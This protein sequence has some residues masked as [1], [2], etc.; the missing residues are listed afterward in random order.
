MH[1]MYDPPVQ[2]APGA[3]GPWSALVARVAGLTPDPGAPGGGRGRHGLAPLA[4]AHLGSNLSSNVLQLQKSQQAPVCPGQAATHRMRPA[5]LTCCF[6]R[7]FTETC[8]HC[9]AF[10]LGSGAANITLGLT[11]APLV[12]AGANILQISPSL[13]STQDHTRGAGASK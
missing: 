2:Y 12:R 5:F 11:P 3:G 4:P 13:S 7:L 9:T 8:Q 6:S 10:T 1:P